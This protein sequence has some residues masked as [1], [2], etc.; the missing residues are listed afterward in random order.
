V[1]T[2]EFDYHLP[3]EL[4]AQ[5]PADKRD[6]SRML[7][8]DRAS[9]EICHKRFDAITG[10]L[11]SGDV[12]V[13]N[14]TKVIPARLIGKKA[15]GAKVEVFLLHP[16][17]EGFWRCLVQPGRKAR[18]GDE[19][20]FAGLMQGQVEEILDDGSRLIHFSYQGQFSEV[21]EKVGQVP[22]PPYIKRE[23]MTEEDRIRYQTVYARADGAVA[24]PTA[25]LHFTPELLETLQEQGVKIAHV[26]LHVGMGT[27]KP[28]TATEITDHKMDSEWFE[29]SAEAAETINSARP[30]GRIIAVGTTS[31]RTLESAWDEEAGGVKAGARWTDIFIYPGYS[32][33]AVDSLITNFHLPK[34]TL[35]M[36]ISAL[37]GQ[38][39]I[40]A[41]YAEAVREKY[42]FYSYGDC[43]LIE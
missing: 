28:V 21:I 43:M 22:L 12:L 4:I 40:R 9:G 1:R 41:A 27:F 19:I 24:A 42:R 26:T 15:T 20:D 6:H 2:D 17:A 5:Q 8:L 35:I 29:I 38:E 33:S 23:K 31:V 30:E 13:L 7:T 11:R 34:S 37:A 10:H 39:K 16:E 3:T 36:L 14:D 18:V 25:G 32:Y